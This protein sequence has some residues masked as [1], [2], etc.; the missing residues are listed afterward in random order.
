MK[1]ECLKSPEKTKTKT[2]TLNLIV[3]VCGLF[4]GYNI[5]C[6]NFVLFCFEETKVTI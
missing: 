3:F 2:K 5:I 6:L 4:F 1:Y